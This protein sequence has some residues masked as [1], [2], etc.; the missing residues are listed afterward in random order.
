MGCIQAMSSFIFPGKECGM[1]CKISDRMSCA[2]ILFGGDFFS[3]AVLLCQKCLQHKHR[4]NWTFHWASN[5]FSSPSSTACT[6]LLHFLRS[7]PPVT[8]F[9]VETCIL[10]QSSPER[11]SKWLLVTGLWMWLCNQAELSR[12]C[13]L[14]TLTALSR[15]AQSCSFLAG[16]CFE[17]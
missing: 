12:L 4:S 13:K 14:H 16:V 2:F 9:M 17:G 10:G 1:P 6:A 7:C 5:R 11:V 3:P 8:E 15:A